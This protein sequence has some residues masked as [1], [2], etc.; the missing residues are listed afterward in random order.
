MPRSFG[1]PF[2]KFSLQT[3]LTVPFVIQ[4]L[5]V[6]GIVGYISYRNGQAAVRD[7]SAQ[8]RSELT[9][10]ILDQIQETV[11]TPYIIN[12]INAQSLA[13]GD[14]NVLTGEG[15]HQLWQQAKVFPSTNLIYC[16][17]EAEGAFLGSG[18]SQGGLGDSLAIQDSNESTDF[19]MYFY[20]VDA[21][22][23][24]SLLRNKGSKKYDPRKRPWYIAAKEQRQPTWSEI[25]LDFDTLLP[26]IT[27]ATP[28]Y[29]TDTKALIGV[30]AT[31]IMLARELNGFLT[32]LKIGKSGIAFILEPSG[33]LVASST[34]EAITRGER[35]KTELLPAIDS[36]NPLIK[37]SA[38]YLQRRVAK[39]QNVQS[40][41]TDFYLNNKPHFVQLVRFDDGRG[42]DWLVVLVIPESDFMERINANNRMTILLSILSLLIAISVGIVTTR[43][44]AKPILSLNK[45]AKDVAKGEW[46]KAIEL[47]RSDEL[48][49]LSRSF[50][51]M[52]FQLKDSFTTLEHRVDERTKELAEANQEI[53]NL[54]ERLK[55]DNMR[56]SAELNVAQKIQ[57]MILPK[58]HELLAIPELEISGVMKPADEVGGDYYDVFQIDDLVTIGIGDVTGHGLESGVLM[59]MT[60][61]AIRTIGELRERD[62]VQFLDTLN[63]TIYHNIQ[64]M[65]S[66][67]NLTLSILNYAAGKLKI[68]GQHEEPLLVRKS[69]KIQRVDT[70][71]LGLPIGLV[72]EISP[73]VDQLSIDLQPGDGVV[74]YTDGIIEAK[75]SHNQFY[76]I[77]RLCELIEQHWSCSV[78]ELEKV[79]LT[80]LWEFIGDR[81]L[82]DDVTLVILK[83]R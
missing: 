49:E 76:G 28:V 59:L 64:R 19:Y 12:Q 55:E 67:R 53:S 83:R 61:T 37:A 71:D 16:G 1:N 14:I 77:E 79:V 34:P 6:V 39:F 43:W 73:F 8:L 23:N 40:I 68:M 62:P 9:A 38:K 48:G 66:D 7:L 18:R 44:I 78:A 26:T 2:N 5:A 52:A 3:V 51:N 41:Q 29:D 45:A 35:E 60:Q 32:R 81:K 13:Q 36:S 10:R 42:L 22:G 70:M 11:D 80:D 63:R 58:S 65:N 75:N 50:K 17:T 72:D 69:G 74:L 33:K 47:K 4:V 82:A 31:D 30:C 57:E 56:M 21:R 25:Y 24:R 20:D 54:N 27:A 15:E 46:D